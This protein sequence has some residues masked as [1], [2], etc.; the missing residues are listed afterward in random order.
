MLC[1]FVR[2]GNRA[3]NVYADDCIVRGFEDRREISCYLV[4]P[5]AHQ[6]FKLRHVFRQ[7]RHV[8]DSLCQ[9]SYS[10]CGFM[11]DLTGGM[12][13]RFTKKSKPSAW[14]LGMCP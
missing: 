2:T 12:D 6:S 9:V 1:A 14:A 13:R 7:P 10:T 11:V 4:G 8:T 5:F 3:V